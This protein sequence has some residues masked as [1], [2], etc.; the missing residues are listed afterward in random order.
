MER[1]KIQNRE[2]NLEREEQSRRNDTAS[3][4]DP[5]Q[6]SQLLLDKGAKII[7]WSK[8]SLFNK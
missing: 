5:D 6:Y 8:N 2:H 1:Q 7:Q 4:T 3:E